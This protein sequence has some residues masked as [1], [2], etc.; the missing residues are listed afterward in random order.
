MG[1]LV[2]YLNILADVLSSVSGSMIPPGMEPS[3][4][5]VMTGITAFF[6]L[7]LG[8]AVKSEQSM[9]A[10]SKLVRLP[11]L[12]IRRHAP[13]LLLT[14]PRRR[15]R[16]HS[17]ETDRSAPGVCLQS[18]GLILVFVVVVLLRF[19]TL[20]TAVDSGPLVMWDHSRILVSFPV[21]C[22]GF[23]AHVVMLPI[24]RPMR[25]LTLR[26]ARAAVRRSLAVCASLYWTVGALAYASF[27][28]RT[29][30]DLLRNF[31]GGGG[32]GSL[33]R[34][35]QQCSR[36]TDVRVGS[37]ALCLLQLRSSSS[38]T[39]GEHKRDV[40]AHVQGKRAEQPTGADG[41]R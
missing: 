31:G 27:R 18:I 21:M 20:P 19:L 9:G 37:V 40:G 11:P 17:R 34:A 5:A 41:G 35:P 22:F 13:V 2:G 14:L 6:F 30:G 32:T 15:R 7:P 29:A 24:V 28:D 33:V 8:V 16:T 26:R 39:R 25:H 3:R 36:E 1:G 23:C 10:V 4:F 12:P 38:T